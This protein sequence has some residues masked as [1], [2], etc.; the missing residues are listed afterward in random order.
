MLILF[1]KYAIIPL[2][3]NSAHPNGPQHESIVKIVI[4][5]QNSHAQT[6]MELLWLYIQTLPLSYIKGSG[7]K[8]YTYNSNG[9]TRYFVWSGMN[10]VYE[11]DSGAIGGTVYYYGINRTHSSEGEFYRYNVRPYTA[12]VTIQCLLITQRLSQKFNRVYSN[13][14]IKR[15]GQ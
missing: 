13:E 1:S 3:Q 11:Y 7:I 8:L 2:W 14:L 10:L 9:S 15:Q 5:P 4:E 12:Q 6:G